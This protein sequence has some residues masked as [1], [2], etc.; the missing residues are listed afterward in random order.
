MPRLEKPPM[1]VIYRIPMVAEGFKGH[2]K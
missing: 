2:P 1:S